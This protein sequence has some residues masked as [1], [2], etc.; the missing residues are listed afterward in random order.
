MA[1]IVGG[2]SAD[3]SLPT[4]RL[5]ERFDLAGMVDEGIGI[6]K[7]AETMCTFELV[8]HDLTFA[9]EDQQVDLV[10]NL[11]NVTKV[12][13]GKN[14]IYLDHFR[15]EVGLPPLPAMADA[16]PLTR[17]FECERR[18]MGPLYVTRSY[19]TV[20]KETS[21]TKR[22]LLQMMFARRSEEDSRDSLLAEVEEFTEEMRELG[23][24]LRST[25][26][27]VA[28]LDSDG[29]LTYLHAAITPW[30]PQAVRTPDPAFYLDEYL[31]EGPAQ[32]ENILRYNDWYV[33]MAGIRDFPGSTHAGMMTRLLSSNMEFRVTTRFIFADKEKVKKEIEAQRTG[34]Y[35]K[36]KGLGKIAQEAILKEASHL[37]DT[38]ALS[39]VADASAAMAEL[40]VGLSFGLATTTA[41]T[42]SKVSYEEARSLLEAVMKTANDEGFITKEERMNA[43]SAFLGSIPGNLRYNARRHR[44]S[45]AN[46]AHFFLLSSPYMG[47]PVNRYMREV[48]GEGA[49][50]LIAKTGHSPFF[51]ESHEGD[52]GNQVRFG[53]TGAGKS[54]LNAATAVCDLKYRGV[55]VRFFDKGGSSR[56][57]TERCGGVFVEINREE[58]GLKLNPF[59]RADRGPEEQKFITDLVMNYLEAV[60][61]PLLPE[62]V[63]R[64]HD[65]TVSAAQKSAEIRGWSLFANDVQDVGIRETLKPFLRGGHYYDLFKDGPDEISDA[66]WVTF[67]M[68]DLMRAPGDPVVPLIFHYLFHR[69]EEEFS[70][71]RPTRVYVDEASAFLDS[72]AFEGIIKNLLRTARKNGGSVVLATQ[73]VAAAAESS[74]FQTILTNCPTKILLPNS[75]AM[76]AGTAKL[77]REIGLSDADLR[78]LA[79]ATPKRD[80]LYVSPT[81]S[82]LFRLDLSEDEL[83]LLGAKELTP[84]AARLLEAAEGE[85]QKAESA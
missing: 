16:P 1:K 74:V 77:Y 4:P 9:R 82:Q 39:Q 30:N 23:N 21:E 11:R 62:S 50:L 79:N 10:R 31:A 29:F 20:C 19:L 71:S 75:L 67:E 53:P 55:R 76:Q 40:A 26:K 46:L 5:A 84:R 24:M 72:P 48:T 51:L 69:I 27:R 80:Y 14:T 61:Y 60:R 12:F 68:G 49:P 81:A 44:T 15:R 66:R 85:T 28:R 32:F 2:R 6:T 3:L 41:E 52:V 73:E 54:V 37:E 65:A 38:E 47:D 70:P 59:A 7:S 25:F 18:K 58:S 57:A 78:I 33:C 56:W 8:P 43:P 64:I 17:V 45:T 63:T 42:W 36:R 83:S 35:Q 13:G 22:S 34:A